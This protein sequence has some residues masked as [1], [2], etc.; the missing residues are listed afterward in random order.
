MKREGLALQ[1]RNS[2][3]FLNQFVYGGII[4]SFSQE[5]Y[6]EFNSD[7][8]NNFAIPA[9]GFIRKEF[10]TFI[11]R[12]GQY[13]AMNFVKLRIWQNV[14]YFVFNFNARDNGGAGAFENSMGIEIQNTFPELLGD[15]VIDIMI[16]C[17]IVNSIVNENIRTADVAT[18]TRDFNSFILGFKKDILGEHGIEYNPVAK[19]I[20]DKGSTLQRDKEYPVLEMRG[21]LTLIEVNKQE[22]LFK[23][24]RF[25]IS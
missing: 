13:L 2:L 19:C 21:D 11:F 6:C 10:P 15:G 18:K 20:N 23:T 8:F 12:S 25:E 14:A 1:T 4:R 3:Y 7:Y 24:K 16:P 17:S 9:D 5:S 22:K